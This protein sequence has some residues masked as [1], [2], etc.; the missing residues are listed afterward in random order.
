MRLPSVA[1]FRQHVFLVAVNAVVLPMIACFL[2]FVC[3]RSRSPWLRK[4]IGVWLN[5][6]LG[7]HFSQL[8]EP[9]DS[10]SPAAV[11]HE[12]SNVT[13]L[14]CM[15]YAIHGPEDD[16]FEQN[17][18]VT[19]VRTADAVIVYNPIPLSKA[20][21]REH[22][23]D[24]A[25]YWI[26]LPS[27]YHHLYV[28]PYLDFLP[29]ERVTVVGSVQAG[30]R[31]NPPLSVRHGSALNVPGV[32]VLETSILME[33][34]NLVVPLHEGGSLL[35]VGHLFQCGSMAFGRFRRRHW[36]LRAL[37]SV[38]EYLDDF[39]AGGCLDLFFWAHLTDA[40][41][42]EESI[43]ALRALEGVRGVV[44]SHGGLCATEPKE[45]LAKQLAWG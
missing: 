12:F 3:K 36:A 30:L 10:Q 45:L 42:S 20:Q 2:G 26:V 39:D 13:I 41:D 17:I 33:E 25:H 38:L 32:Q 6:M 11:A 29:P 22:L 19:I 8:V 37:E 15:R 23:P 7:E 16:L 40:N 14:G 1:R 24:A 44:C 21:M 27:R 43:E 5:R 35:L 28:D 18:T 34:Y 9:P 31:H 4:R